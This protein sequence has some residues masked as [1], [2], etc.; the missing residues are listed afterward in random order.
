MTASPRPPQFNF[1]LTEEQSRQ[2][3][4]EAKRLGVSKA[5]LIRL[6]VFHNFKLAKAARE[7]G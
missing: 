5:D 1:I 4:A 6:Q 2:L 3:E 7:G